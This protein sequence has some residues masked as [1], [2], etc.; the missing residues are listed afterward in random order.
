[1]GEARLVGRGEH[2]VV[3]AAAGPERA[4]PTRP[5]A[6]SESV[7][8]SRAARGSAV[9]YGLALFSAMVFATSGSLAKPLLEAGW[10][11]GAT[12]GARMLGAAVLL[13]VPTLW[14]LRGRWRSVAENWKPIGLF[15][16]F[17]VAIC[18]FSYFQAVQYLEVSVALLLEYLAPILIVLGTWAVTRRSPR[19]LTILGALTAIAGLILV[20]D[21]TGATGIDP[22]GVLW[23][24]AAAVGLAVFF[25]I[26]A[27]QNDTLHPLVLT[28]FGLAVGASLMFGLGALGILPMHA[29]FGRV[30]FAGF[31]APWWGA[32]GGLVI[33][34]AVL[35]YLSGILAARALG[36]TMASFIGL[37][38]VVFAVVWAWLLLGEMPA[39]IQLLGGVG[40]VAGVVLVRTDEIRNARRLMA[41]RAEPALPA[42]PQ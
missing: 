2:G 13:L 29:S 28:T 3:H 26:S 35:A 31:E 17:G 27:Q 39:P 38:E 9:G 30:T 41:R 18:Q 33:I 37:T 36:A 21:L 10:S 14:V 40:I 12:V 22:V 8:P 25:V 7:P 15:G 34:A 23:G 24:L 42:E 19:L 4:A 11:S 20:L 5:A 6:G 16:L 1:M 32:L